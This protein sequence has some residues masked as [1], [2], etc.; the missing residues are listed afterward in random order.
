MTTFLIITFLSNSKLCWIKYVAYLDQAILVLYVAVM[1][2]A[3]FWKRQT[4]SQWHNL[5]VCVFCVKEGYYQCSWLGEYS[6]IKRRWPMKFQF[7]WKIPNVG[8]AVGSTHIEYR[9]KMKAAGNESPFPMASLGRHVTWHHNRVSNVD[10]TQ[11]CRVSTTWCFS[12][13]GFH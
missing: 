9:E 1:G 7:Q 10:T 2:T 12:Y 6:G 5:S 8:W 13:Y 4:K 3:S 11:S